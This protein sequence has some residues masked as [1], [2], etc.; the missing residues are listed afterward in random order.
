MTK[1]IKY[2]S[3]LPVWFDLNNY[4]TARTLSMYEWH[5]QLVFRKHCLTC[6]NMSALAEPIAI[7]REKTVIKLSDHHHFNLWY[8]VSCMMDIQKFVTTQ[9]NNAISSLTM[10][11]FFNIDKFLLPERKTYEPELADHVIDIM[12]FFPLPLILLLQVL[13]ALTPQMIA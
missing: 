8:G 11:N 6:P 3:E 7:M 1:K 2:K 4:K 13:N 10:R 12:Q 9:A 5:I